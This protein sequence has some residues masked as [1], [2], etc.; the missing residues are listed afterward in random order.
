MPTT[1]SDPAERPS[2]HPRARPNR[3]RSRTFAALAD[4]PE[5][6]RFYFGQGVSLIGTWVQNAAALWVAYEMTGSAWWLGVIEA[7]AILP[8]LFVGLFA[9][10]LADRVAPRRF[11]VMTL[12]GQ[13]LLAFL[14]AF[15]V[16]TG[17][18]RI[19]HIA[20]I[21]A[22]N[23]VCVAFEMPTRQVL[24][25]DLVGRA[26]LMNAIALN[27][28]IFNAS[29]VAGPA[30][31]GQLLAGFGA[32]ACFALNGVS[33][34]AA[35]GALLTIRPRGRPV[36]PAG[37]RRGLRSLLGGFAFLRQDRRVG[38]LFA[39]M[40]CFGIIGMGY[41]ALL[42][43]YARVVVGT[44]AVGYSVLLSSSG[45]GA[46]FGALI[47]ASVGG[48][49]RKEH[50]VLGGMATFGLAIGAAGL[51]PPMIAALGAVWAVLPTA[52]ACLFVIGFGG[53]LFYSSTQ[54]LIQTAVPDHLRGRIMGLWMIA[55]SG[56]VP[57]GSLWA[58][59][60]AGR[61]GIALILQLSAVL[62][63]GTAL[64]VFLSGLLNEPE[65]PTTH[66]TGDNG[67]VR[68]LSD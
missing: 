15:L 64:A 20:A 60:S 6:R 33:Y 45:L 30:L 24:L 46:T 29:R 51:V 67:Q 58:G 28:G 36:V 23:R 17:R 34:L 25:Y 37:E 5:Y 65:P 50:L 19:W 32:A 49:R 42:P 1:S 53:I 41:Q 16:W 2:P 56:S 52:A 11:I 38:L 22:L 10:A 18:V 61:F 59:W 4:N 57:V 26:S 44:G 47:V 21:L 8:G 31:A 54:T 12:V 63:I 13:M 43:A 7:S 68:D 27:S 66:E 35:I 14:L 55:F 40:V 39:Q 9:G 3:V 48:L 62:C